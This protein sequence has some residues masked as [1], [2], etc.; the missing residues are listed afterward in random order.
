MSDS[1]RLLIN[2]R[3]FTGW[4]AATISMSI[5]NCAD[6]FSL[7]APFD[8]SDPAVKAAFVPRKYQDV[9]VKIGDD[10]VLTGRV[11][12]VAP[13]TGPDRPHAQRP[14]PQPHRPTCRL[15]H[16]RRA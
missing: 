13:H 14:R 10:T 8:P 15:L 2:G 4:T 6:A 12:K 9:Q 3:E 1:V 7:T 11:E 5:D 16:R